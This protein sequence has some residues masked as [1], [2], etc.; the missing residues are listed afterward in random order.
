[1]NLNNYSQFRGRGVRKTLKDTS[2][3][4]AHDTYMTDSNKVVIDFDQAKTRYCNDLGV[5]N[6]YAT[7]A[8]ALCEGNKE[9]YYLI[10]FK[11]GDFENSEISRK[12]KDSAVVFSG[13]TGKNINEIREMVTFILVYNE[14]VKRIQDKDKR[15]IALANRG[16]CDFSL[17][18]LSQLRGFYYDHVYALDKEKFDK[19][20]YLRDI[21]SL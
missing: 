9:A 3:D 10:E 11:N 21:I 5:S 13:I 15:A 6:E 4:E 8:D 18:G 2:Y 20:R 7:S 14:N 19:S 16:K 1:M 17:F 12:A